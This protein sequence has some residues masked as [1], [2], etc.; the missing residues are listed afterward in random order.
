MQ[1]LFISAAV[2]LL[3]LVL[4]AEHVLNRFIHSQKSKRLLALQGVLALMLSLWLAWG[5]FSQL[6]NVWR[7]AIG[8]GVTLP[9]F[10]L[11]SFVTVEVWRRIRQQD[12][13]REIHRI[14]RELDETVHQ[15]ERL[16][17]ESEGVQRRERIM[18]AENRVAGRN[19]DDER[20]RLEGQIENWQGGGG[21]ARVR[22]V[23][24]QGWRQEIA[25]LDDEALK[26]RIGSLEMR[27]K[28]LP[29]E[30]GEE[31]V[32]SF[33]QRRAL[34][35]QMALA[36]LV[37]MERATAETSDSPASEDPRRPREFERRRDL[38]ERQ[39]ETLQQEMQLWERKRAA[40]L[41]DRIPLN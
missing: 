29:A 16:R 32:P 37:L 17:W 34:D 25:A 3:L 8:L 1:F 24:V 20:Y 14:R 15:L 23:K 19:Q 4:A 12:F 9:L 21:M 38:L 30:N 26:G 28:Q 6:Q 13:D 35:V 36:R 22:S 5:A 41:E 33:E 39:A 31:T 7:L 27:R 18:A 11:S 10:I 40:F 2:L